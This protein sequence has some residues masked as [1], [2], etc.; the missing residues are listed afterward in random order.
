LWW[1]RISSVAGFKHGS[2]LC[3]FY[4]TKDDSIDLVLPFF[5]H[6]LNGGDASAPQRRRC[7][8]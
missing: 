7:G 6:G 2:H 4:E 3:A 1:S 5:A 8:C